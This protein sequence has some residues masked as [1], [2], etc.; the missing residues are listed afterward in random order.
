MRLDQSVAVTG[1]WHTDASSIQQ[2]MMILLESSSGPNVDAMTS[3]VVSRIRHVFQSLYRLQRN[4]E[5]NES[6]QR[7]RLYVENMA[8]PMVS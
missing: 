2:A 7:Y 5:K 3:E 6:A 4:R 8:S 1:G